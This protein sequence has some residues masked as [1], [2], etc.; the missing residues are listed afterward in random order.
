[1]VGNASFPGAVDQ[2]T[3]GAAV[4]SKTLDYLNNN[5]PGPGFGTGL[6]P[7]DQQTF[8]ASV[9]NK[10]LDYMNSGGMGGGSGFGGVSQTYDFAKDVLGTYLTGQGA[11]ANLYT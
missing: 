9:V 10:T 2:Q 11:I 1:M 7:V 4:V 5:S 3:F 8:G 6:A